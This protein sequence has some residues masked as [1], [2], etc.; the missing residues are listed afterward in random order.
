M[1][2]EYEA[3]LASSRKAYAKDFA[4]PPGGIRYPMDHPFLSRVFLDQATEIFNR[5]E[6]AGAGDPAILRRVERAELPILY[7]QLMRGPAF[8]GPG[9]EAMIDRFERIARRE[10]VTWTAEATTPLDAQ[11]AAWRKQV[12]AKPAAATQQ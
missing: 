1:L 4:N 3:L 12:P 11:L 10:G 7:V 5:A 9:F 6:K 8:V 2:G